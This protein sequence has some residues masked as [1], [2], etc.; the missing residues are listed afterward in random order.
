MV[1][2]TRAAAG[3]EMMVHPGG[4]SWLIL[5]IVWE[6]STVRGTAFSLPVEL[7]AGF[8]QVQLY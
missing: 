3:W 6:E 4:P 1:M 8:V 7:M 2:V 5:S